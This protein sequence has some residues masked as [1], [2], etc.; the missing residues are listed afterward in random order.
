MNCEQDLRFLCFLLLDASQ[1]LDAGEKVAPN[2]DRRQAR[3][4]WTKSQEAQM[5]WEDF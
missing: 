3:R 1:R 5:L 2:M 4:N